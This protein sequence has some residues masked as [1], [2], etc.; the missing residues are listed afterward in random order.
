VHLGS[1]AVRE[2]IVDLRVDCAEIANGNV[3]FVTPHL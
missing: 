1:E 3:Y 2:L